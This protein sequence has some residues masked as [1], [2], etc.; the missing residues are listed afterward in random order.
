M[1]VTSPFV[2]LGF[3]TIAKIGFGIL[4]T[5]GAT[6]HHSDQVLDALEFCVNIG[7]DYYYD[8]I[9]CYFDFTKGLLITGAIL[10]FLSI[11]FE[12]F[13]PNKILIGG[14]TV[15]TLIH[16]IGSLF[17]I[18]SSMYPILLM[19]V[20]LDSFYYDHP[21]FE[22]GFWIAGGLITAL[23]QAYLGYVLRSEGLF[24]VVTYLIAT[25]G[26]VLFMATGIMLLKE[27]EGETHAN[28][29]AGL[30]IS[31]SV[32]YIVHGILYPIAIYKKI[33][34]LT[35]EKSDVPEGEEEC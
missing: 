10:F 9:L 11:L 29:V 8:A 25:L 33:K 3:T 22:G 31:G 7:Q 14:I 35:M 32:L 23:G 30:M 13:G 20:G 15:P 18:V 1:C 27:V 16:G 17:L 24:V 6:Y 5:A 21:D 34:D 26:S 4:F 28:T 2:L 19:R 12:A